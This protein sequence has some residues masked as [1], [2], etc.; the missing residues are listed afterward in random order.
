MPQAG[1]GVTDGE[2]FTGEVQVS[3]RRLADSQLEHAQK[4]FDRGLVPPRLTLSL[5]Q[6]QIKQANA[7]VGFDAGLEQP[8]RFVVPSGQHEVHSA[9]LECI[10]VS[11][12]VFIGLS[13]GQKLPIPLKNTVSFIAPPQP[14]KRCPPDI[15]GAAMIGRLLEHA[16]GSAE[17]FLEPTAAPVDFGESVQ[18]IDAVRSNAG[19]T[20]KKRLRFVQTVAPQLKVAQRDLNCEVAGFQAEGRSVGRQGPVQPQKVG[21]EVA[22]PLEDQFGGDG[23][24]PP[25][26]G[27]HRVAG[28]GEPSMIHP[29]FGQIVVD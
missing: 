25:T 18:G 24:I 19:D 21:V 7:R 28:L 8:D 2:I 14:D 22:Q 23:S 17:R 16:V 11:T 13:L 20:R 26:G 27:F 12:P 15:Q 9:G 4:R 29:Q 1:L 6:S 10:D 5:P 3:R